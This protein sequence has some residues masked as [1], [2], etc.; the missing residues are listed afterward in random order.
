MNDLKTAFFVSA[1]ERAQIPLPVD[2]RK[3]RPSG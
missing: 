3:N 2:R 1:E